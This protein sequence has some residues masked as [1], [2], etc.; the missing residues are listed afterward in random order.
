MTTVQKLDK[1]TL[2]V[3]AQVYSGKPGKCACGCSG[4]YF[5]AA[6][7]IAE[8]NKSHG[9]D[10]SEDINEKMV[11]KIFHLLQS[12]A[13]TAEDFGNGFSVKI[14]NREYNVYPTQGWLDTVDLLAKEEAHA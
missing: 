3:V 5:N 9:Y 2:N 4:K 6:A 10:C 12:V 7:H 14:S 13:D 8:I 1:L 11:K